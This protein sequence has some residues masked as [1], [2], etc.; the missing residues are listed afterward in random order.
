MLLFIICTTCTLILLL[1]V[2]GWIDYPC[3]C[4][5]VRPVI[6]W[7]ILEHDRNGEV[8]QW[9]FVTHIMEGEPSLNHILDDILV[10]LFLQ[11][12]DQAKEKIEQ[13][14]LMVDELIFTFAF[15]DIHRL[16]VKHVYKLHKERK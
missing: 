9:Y 5:L 12:D 4:P 8:L 16:T 7:M 1:W 13:G 11:L 14:T 15:Q 2:I 6:R 10:R 3:Q